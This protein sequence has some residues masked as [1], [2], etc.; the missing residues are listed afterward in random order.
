[1][2]F[3]SQEKIWDNKS[4][5]RKECTLEIEA[6][7]RNLLAGNKLRQKEYA[8]QREDQ[9]DANEGENLRCVWRAKTGRQHPPPQTFRIG[10]GEREAASFDTFGDLRPA[11]LACVGRTHSLAPRPFPPPNRRFPQPSPNLA[12]VLKHP[13]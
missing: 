6:Q 9:D 13:D 1:M 4:H 5:Q 3:I 7:N 8:G 11:S 12:P 2:V 10:V